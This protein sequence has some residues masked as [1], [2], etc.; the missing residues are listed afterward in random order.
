MLEVPPNYCQDVAL[1][2]DLLQG[3]WTLKIL[4]ATRSGPVRLG[5][6][7]RL[8]PDASK[9]V[10]TENLRKLEALGLI[11]RRDMGGQVRH[12][13]YDLVQPMRAVTS[14]ILDHLTRWG[15]LYKTHVRSR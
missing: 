13:E 2:I 5:Q 3:K 10:L 4:C 6:L 15:V 11:A 7:G 12:V 14:D 8:I 1:A 9:K